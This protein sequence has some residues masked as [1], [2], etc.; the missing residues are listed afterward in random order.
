VSEE[1]FDLVVAVNFEA[2]WLPMKHELEAMRS[3]GRGAIVNAACISGVVAAAMPSP[4]NA[5]EH[6][7]VGLTK[8]TA[9]DAAGQA[10]A[11]TASARP[12]SIRR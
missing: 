10:S 8:E 6:A 1:I 5:T 11:S 4:Y 9:V 3:Q 12:T 2:V 7:V